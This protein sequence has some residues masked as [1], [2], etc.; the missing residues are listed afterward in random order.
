MRKR[1]FGVLESRG[2]T[3][4]PAKLYGYFMVIIILT[5]LLPLAFRES[6]PIFDWIE[7]ASVTVF[8]VDYILRL[9]TA[10]LKLHKGALSFLIYP[11]TPMAIIDLLSILP[12]F[13]LINPAFKLMRLLRLVRV[14]RVFKL[15]RYSKSIRIIAR[16]FEDER[17]PL[18]TVLLLAVAYTTCS[19]LIVFNIEPQT[20]GSI[21][22]AFYWAVIS[23]TT[24]GYGDIYPVTWAGRMVAMVSSLVGIA[25]VA[26]PSSII[27]AGYIH[28]LENP[29][30][31]NPDG[32]IEE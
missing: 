21:Y 32:D 7:G 27:T 29:R 26:L 5:S 17:K 4:G 3:S 15:L 28:E 10:D 19:A 13:S 24:V 22:D 6:Y 14:L 18:T 1:L 20:F 30:N 31:A 12:A 25:I 9:M 8:V 11:V 23:L 2:E 16:V